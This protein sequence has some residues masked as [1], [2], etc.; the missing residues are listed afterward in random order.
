MNRFINK[1]VVSKKDINE[2][3]LQIYLKTPLY[4]V[5]YAVCILFIAS[6]LIDFFV[7]HI[8]NLS[9]TIPFLLAIVAMVFVFISNGKNMYRQSLDL[10]GNP[11]EY[12]YTAQDSVL[13]LETSDGK[14]GRLE[15]KRIYK[16]FE[17]KNCIAIRG[18]DN[19]FFIL[20]KDGFIEG[21]FDTFKLEI[22]DLL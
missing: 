19:S 6:S 16:I 20:K 3:N 14:H 5:L 21:D 10:N 1:T 12:T 2:I 8:I 11:I 17:S 4:L 7:N 15:Y 22:K 9:S 13:T 18:R